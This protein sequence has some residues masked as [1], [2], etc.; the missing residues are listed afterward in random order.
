MTSRVWNEAGH[1]VGHLALMNLHPVGFDDAHEL[2]EAVRLVVDG[3][4]GYLLSSGR[5]FHYYGQR[6][7]SVPDW[8]RFLS[9]FLMPC[10][11]VSPRYIGHSLYR[12]F[13]SLRL[14][15]APPAKPVTPSLINLD[16]TQ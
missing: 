13:C 12:G 8:P 3:T 2:S 9:Q 1:Q 14:N 10:V 6:L 16:D 7:L 15:A 5:Y 4:S 11:L